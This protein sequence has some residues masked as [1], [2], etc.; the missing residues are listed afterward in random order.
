M[1]EIKIDLT[2]ERLRIE[3]ENRLSKI[4]RDFEATF[5]VPSSVQFGAAMERAEQLAE[6][7]SKPQG[8]DVAIDLLS[9]VVPQ[10]EAQTRAFWSTALGQAIAYLSGAAALYSIDRRMVLEVV[11]GITR[12]GTYKIQADMRTDRHGDICAED[13]RR[14]LQKRMTR[15]DGGGS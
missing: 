10:H 13:L 12:Q 3:L 7:L 15:A 8:I 1:E 5:G 14:Y 2:S 9:H 4:L 11:T 6:R